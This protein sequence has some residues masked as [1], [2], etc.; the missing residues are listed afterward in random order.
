M[1]A[2]LSKAEVETYLGSV[3][4]RTPLEQAL[5]AAVAAQAKMPADFFADYFAKAAKGKTPK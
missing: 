2:P 1:P 5:N 3:D 4:L